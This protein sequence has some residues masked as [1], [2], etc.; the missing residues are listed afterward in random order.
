MNKWKVKCKQRH[1][2]FEPGLS[3]PYLMMMIITLCLYQ[4]K[5]YQ[6]YNKSIE[7][8]AVFTK[9]QVN[10]HISYDDKR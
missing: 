3:S 2:E 1:T 5:L 4:F 6:V 8:E 9:A 7:T 10:D